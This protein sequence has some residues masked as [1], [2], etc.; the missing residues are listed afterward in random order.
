MYLASFVVASPIQS[1]FK[2]KLP[3]HSLTKESSGKTEPHRVQAER[4]SASESGLHIKIRGR[5]PP[6]LYQ[7]KLIRVKNANI[8]SFCDFGSFIRNSSKAIRSSRQSSE[9]FPMNLNDYVTR[10]SLSKLA[11]I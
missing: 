7:N 6:S 2:S 11:K 1:K 5:I 9:R 4:Y 3:S 10:Q 8:G